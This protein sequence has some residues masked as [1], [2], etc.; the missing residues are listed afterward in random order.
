MSK[1]G[2]KPLLLDVPVVQVPA[3]LAEMFSELYCGQTLF[4]PPSLCP[5]SQSPSLQAETA[6]FQSSS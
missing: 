5:S 1:L 6:H 2:Q 4:L 3:D